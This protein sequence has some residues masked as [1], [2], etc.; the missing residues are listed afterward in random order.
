M[1]A[2]ERYRTSSSYRSS[3]SGSQA[4]AS[5]D[6]TRK[7]VDRS[8]LDNYTL[9][10]ANTPSFVVNTVLNAAQK[11]RQ[12]GFEKNRSFFQ[13]K[14]L[15]SKNRGGYENTFSSYSQYMK[16]RSAGK[17]DAYGNTLMRG[18]GDDNEPTTIL[19]AQ[20]QTVKQPIIEEEANIKKT[21]K[22]KLLSSNYGQSNI[23]RGNIDDSD[24]NIG[25]TILGG[26]VS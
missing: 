26:G 10:K 11:L 12:K 8:K 13:D 2:R 15:T 7:S 16:D 1:S 19:T 14:V 9:P 24:V 4:K 17:I 18:G 22:R 3:V 25:R 20:A 21:K 23:L 5:R 6:R